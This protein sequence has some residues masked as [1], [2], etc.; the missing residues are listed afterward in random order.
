MLE[1]DSSR[2]MKVIQR[3]RLHAAMNAAPAQEQKSASA[4]FQGRRQCRK[5][6]GTSGRMKIP[7]QIFGIDSHA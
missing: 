2:K 1:Y 3:D 5:E 7:S 6:F 4:Y